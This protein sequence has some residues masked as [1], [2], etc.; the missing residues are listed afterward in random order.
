MATVLDSADYRTFPSQLLM[1]DGFHPFLLGSA[2]LE[3]GLKI[4]V[5]PVSSDC[6]VTAAWRTV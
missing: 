6:L 1:D 2:A 4:V 3:Q 5:S